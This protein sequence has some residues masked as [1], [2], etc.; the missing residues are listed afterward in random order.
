MKTA[1]LE[2]EG[3]VCSTVFHPAFRRQKNPSSTL[4][5]DR[6]FN[7]SQPLAAD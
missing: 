1:L 2:K 6:M 3:G 5:R 4:E 7:T